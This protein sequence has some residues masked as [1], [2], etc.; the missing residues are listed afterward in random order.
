MNNIID[1]ALP[2]IR[3]EQLSRKIH[4]QCLYHDYSAALKMTQD[5]IVEIRVLQ[6]SLKIMQEKQQT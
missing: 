5:M 4:D 6:A 2:L 1:Y 3:I